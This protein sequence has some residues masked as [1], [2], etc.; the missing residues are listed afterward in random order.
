MN[1]Y[2]WSFCSVHFLLFESLISSH[3]FYQIELLFDPFD[4]QT[5]KFHKIPMGTEQGEMGRISQDALRIDEMPPETRAELSHLSVKVAA[6]SSHGLCCLP[7]SFITF[8]ALE[9]QDLC[10]T[11]DPGTLDFKCDSGLRAMH[12]SLDTSWCFCMREI[13]IPHFTRSIEKCD[14]HYLYTSI[15]NF[16]K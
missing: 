11:P 3:L 7:R 12:S 14:S 4:L 1:R 15:S 5:R 2:L 9:R 6:H 8:L 10:L 16:L 13:K